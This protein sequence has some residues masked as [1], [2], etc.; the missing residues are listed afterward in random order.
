MC[1]A[2]SQQ[3]FGVQP[4][5]LE[6]GQLEFSWPGKMVSPRLAMYSKRASTQFM[7][8]LAD[9]AN[10]RYLVSSGGRIAAGCPDAAR[11]LQDVHHARNL[12]P[13]YSRAAAGDGRKILDFDGK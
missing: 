6:V 3:V 8:V 13:T 12:H 1:S 9:P 11:P 10:S 2:Q 4:P 5:G 7:F